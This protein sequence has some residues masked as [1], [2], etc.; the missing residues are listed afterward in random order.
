[1][2]N[3]QGQAVAEKS[4]KIVD[5]VRAEY[6]KAANWNKVKNYIDNGQLLVDPDG[7]VRFRGSLFTKARFD[8]AQ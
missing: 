6:R 8:L 5:V 4:R 3:P 1:M 2:S 7:N